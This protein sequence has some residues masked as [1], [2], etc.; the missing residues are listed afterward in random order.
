[1]LF[2]S[3][4][5][6]VI[7]CF[8]ADQVY[9]NIEYFQRNKKKRCYGL[10]PSPNQIHYNYLNLRTKN[11]FIQPP[12]SD[13][14]L[15][16]FHSLH[17]FVVV[18]SVCWNFLSSCSKF[19]SLTL[20]LMVYR[21]YIKTLLC[22]EYDLNLYVIRIFLNTKM[23]NSR[24]SSRIVYQ[25]QNIFKKEIDSFRVKRVLNQIE[26]NSIGQCDNINGHFSWSLSYLTAVEMMR[27]G[28]RNSYWPHGL[29][30][31]YCHLAVHLTKCSKIFLYIRSM[32]TNNPIIF[33]SHKML[34]KK[35]NFK[36]GG[37]RCSIWSN[38]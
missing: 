29:T 23:A 38:R 35:C 13:V 31:S 21:I 19:T 4:P 30:I 17:A 6:G 1:M 9:K 37:S 36:P 14:S 18:G 12:V 28:F 24:D 15:I 22:K 25:E 10:G 33:I 32:C 26:S 2:Q 8:K 11:H 34:N 27:N 20:I 16:V 5:C 3:N 7:S